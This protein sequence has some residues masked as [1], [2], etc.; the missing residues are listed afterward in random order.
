[1]NNLTTKNLTRLATL[2]ALNI[3]LSYIYIPLGVDLKITFAF[4]TMSVIG[5]LYGPIVA[6]TSGLILDTLKFLVNPTGIYN[7]LWALTEV[8]A[9]VLYGLCLHNKEINLTR[10]MIT[11]F[12]VNL[13]CNVILTSLLM[14]V[15]YTKGFIY[16]AGSRIIKNLILFPLEGFIM[17][18]ILLKVE[19]WIRK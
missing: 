9:G 5:Y 19:E 10:C 1:M 18:Y 7:P 17:T 15:L 12:L 11:K 6:G 3:L 8:L 2:Y 13:L 14:S 16:Y 4:L